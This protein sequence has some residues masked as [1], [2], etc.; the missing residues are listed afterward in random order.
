MNY[1]I[2]ELNDL[3]D[4]LKQ[5]SCKDIEKDTFIRYRKQFDPK[6]PIWKN[7]DDEELMYRI[8]ILNRTK[9]GTYYLTCE[10]LL[11]FGTSE[12]IHKV[13][14]NYEVIYETYWNYM[15]WKENLFDFFVYVKRNIESKYS[16]TSQNQEVFSAVIEGILNCICNIERYEPWIHISQSH[17]RIVIENSGILSLTLETAKH[18]GASCPKNR[19]IKKIFGFIG[20]G[21][22]AGIGIPM[23][24]ETW[25]KHQWPDPE[26]RLNNK[27][28]TTSFILQVYA[29]S[30]S[31]NDEIA[32]HPSFK[33]IWC[34]LNEHEYA[35]TRDIED[36]LNIKS[37]RARQLLNDLAEKGVV[38]KTGAN[39]NRKYLL[40]K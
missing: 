35:K 24:F 5:Y 3:E 8:G 18:G 15:E 10:G 9:E 26:I 22:S 36:L 28:R 38:I 21:E 2:K 16:K 32:N 7:L 25:K 34:Y 11:L 33:S 30:E 13:F 31:A 27:K 20:Y 14:P 39:K 19:V 37:A 29:C 40:C 4:T 23:I 6:N 17:T 1:F 12:V